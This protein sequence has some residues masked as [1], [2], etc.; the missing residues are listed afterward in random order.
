MSVLSKGRQIWLLLSALLFIVMLRPSY[1]WSFMF[2]VDIAFAIFAIILLTLEQPRIKG[3]SLSISIVLFFVLLIYSLVSDD[4]QIFNI[5]LFFIIFSNDNTKIGVYRYCHTGLAILFAV[6]LIVALL[7]LLFNIELP[8]VVLDPPN[9][10]RATKYLQYP[11][12]TVGFYEDKNFMIMRFAGV[13]DEPG[14]VGTLAAIF[15]VVE[16]F[17]FKKWQNY[18]YLLAG[19]FSFSFFF[20]VV[21]IVFAPFFL[22]LKFKSLVGILL[23][24]AILFGLLSLFESTT[25]LGLTEHLFERFEFKDG[26]FAGDNR[27]QPAFDRAYEEF[28]NDGSYVLFGKGVGAHNKIALGLQS[29]KMMIYDLGIVYVLLSLFYFVLYGFLVL[30]KSRKELFLYVLL[31]LFFYYNRPAYLFTPP[32]FF[33][34]MLAPLLMK[35]NDNPKHVMRST[36]KYE[37]Y[38]SVLY[39]K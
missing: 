38:P 32:Y 10:V 24:G 28:W 31:L 8:S 37:N 12:L 1:I 9:N 3:Y 20:F 15:L 21:L 18:I 39:T 22:R 16:R 4:L 23:I 29:Y 19:V 13:F 34:F 6:S 30:K 36:S 25:E 26:H 17:N 5:L 35:G 27:S 33:L 14:V 11:L 7:V 2:V